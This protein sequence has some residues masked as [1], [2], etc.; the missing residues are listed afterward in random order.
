MNREA[1]VPI[2]IAICCLIALGAAAATLDSTVGTPGGSFWGGGT[3]EG[4]WSFPFEDDRPTGENDSRAPPSAG[5]DGIGMH[6]LAVCIPILTHP[7]VVVGI[8]ALSFGALVAVAHR[9]DAIVSF[10]LL[11][12]IGPFFYVFYTI[13]STCD[14][15]WFDGA[16]ERFSPPADPGPTENDS[17]PFGAGEGVDPLVT[18]PPTVV[19][20]L[21]VAILIGLLLAGFALSNRA[22]DDGDER[23]TSDEAAVAAVG[24]AA[25]RAADRIENA[26]GIENEVYRAWR[27][28]TELLSVPRPES[29]TPAEFADAAIEAGMD[30]GDVTALTDVFREV[31]YGGVTPD[32]ERERR[33]IEALRRIERQYAE[34]AE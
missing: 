8:L 7:L 1:L 6:A 24:R 30:R 23:T 14:V 4:S 9:T 18:A 22:S 13:F 5:S 20:G 29:S 33:A 25:G 28:M 3:G 19:L 31:R 11:V 16:V 32:A 2:L 17:A 26:D 15:P 21:V 12:A 10:A 27:E 34:G